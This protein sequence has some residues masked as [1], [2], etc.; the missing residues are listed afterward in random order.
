MSHLFVCRWATKGALWM[1]AERKPHFSASRRPHRA[2]TREPRDSLRGPSD[3][4]DDEEDLEDYKNCGLGIHNLLIWDNE[5]L[6][7]QVDYNPP[8]VLTL[9]LHKFRHGRN[10]FRLR[11]PP[12]VHQTYGLFLQKKLHSHPA[13]PRAMPIISCRAPTSSA[14][15]SR[16]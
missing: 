15:H 13:Q 10:C 8:I 7:E 6:D 4:E 3:E 12:R 5:P 9:P 11:H 1:R 2:K 14:A 16:H